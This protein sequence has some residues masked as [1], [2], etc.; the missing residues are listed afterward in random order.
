MNTELIL[1]TRIVILALI[2]YSVAIITEQRKHKVTNS[3]LIFLSS[4]IIFDI[5]ATVFM[6]IGSKNSPFTLHGF[7]GYSALLA[8]LVDFFLLWKHRIQ[9]DAETL[10]SNKLHLYSRY[11]YAW[12]MIAFITGGL[13]VL[14]K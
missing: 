13:L 5:V 2:A 14:L 4:G 1:G 10:V 11:A 12:W 7:L 8:M 3:V 6:I 9:N